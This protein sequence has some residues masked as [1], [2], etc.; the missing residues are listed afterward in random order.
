MFGPPPSII[1]LLQP[2]QDTSVPK[3]DAHLHTDVHISKND[4]RRSS[5]QTGVCRM[6]GHC[7]IRKLQVG[8]CC[9]RCIV[10]ISSTHHSIKRIPRQ[11]TL[12]LV[13]ERILMANTTPCVLPGNPV[14]RRLQALHD[15][16]TA[17]AFTT[18][19]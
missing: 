19:R 11:L 14:S 4:K 9:R 1:E 12:I 17:H 16:S 3:S 7:G 13:N 8:L 15:S 10:N 2:D 5:I 6:L 18:S